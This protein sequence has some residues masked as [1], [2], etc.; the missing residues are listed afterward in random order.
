MYAVN[1]G[2]GE[3]RRWSGA[4]PDHQQA[5][6][7]GPQPAVVAS[8]PEGER[9]GQ[10][11]RGLQR[12]NCGPLVYCG[13]QGEVIPAVLTR[14]WELQNNF[15]EYEKRP[16]VTN[17]GEILVDSFVTIVNE[18]FGVFV[19]SWN[20][21]WTSVDTSGAVESMLRFKTHVYGNQGDK[22]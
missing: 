18:H 1:S 11:R 13:P 10:G 14:K 6:A 22:M 19:L 3:A 9:R 17:S 7:D 15:V 4:A 12:P 8:R 5:V 16:N 21:W 2:S 20:A